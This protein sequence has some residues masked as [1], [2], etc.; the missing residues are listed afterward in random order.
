[1][2]YALDMGMR[3][4]LEFCALDFMRHLSRSVRRDIQSTS[5]NI[6]S[7]S[8]GKFLIVSHDGHWD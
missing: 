8:I 7:S 4:V 3:A 6:E 1:M 5:V 2:R